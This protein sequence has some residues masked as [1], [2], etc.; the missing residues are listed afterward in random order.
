MIRGAGE[1]SPL[2]VL[3]PPETWLIVAR[4]VRIEIDVQAGDSIAA[5]S[6]DV[7]E[8]SAGS[9]STCPRL[10]PHLAVRRAFDDEVVAGR[11]EVH[12]VVVVLNVFHDAFE[13][14]DHLEQRLPSRSETELREI[15]L[16]VFM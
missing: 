12:A 14:S 4:V 11:N 6:E 16:R 10:S 1:P 9:R 8:S 2:A 5:K 15:D 7:A 3:A 13:P